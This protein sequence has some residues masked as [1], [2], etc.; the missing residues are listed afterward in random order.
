MAGV[1]ETATELVVAG[2]YA[3][4]E[5]LLRPHVNRKRDDSAAAFLLGHALVR[6]GKPEQALFY[7]ERAAASASAPPGA[8]V[9]FGCTLF[10]LG[11][12]QAGIDVLSRA[13]REHSGHLPAHT[14]LSRMLLR[15]G[16]FVDAMESAM[17]ALAL[18][19]RGAEA[20]SIYASC[21]AGLGRAEDAAQWFERAV[22]L[23]PDDARLRANLCFSLCGVAGV[24]PARVF[25]AHREYGAR[26][27]ADAG[28]LPAPQ[29]DRS[30]T[31]RLRVGFVSPD[32]RDH[33]V[34]RFLLP[35]LRNVEKDAF[36][37]AVYAANVE[38]DDMT[39]ALRACAGLWREVPT[40]TDSDLATQIRADGVDV[41]VDLAG[42][43]GGTRL[44]AFAWKPAPVQ[45]TYMGYPNT[46]GVAGV[47]ARLVDAI[48]DPPGAES[49]ASEALVRL[50]GCFL[51]FDASVLPDVG[52]GAPART[53]GVVFGSFNNPTKLSTHAL[54]LWARVLGANPG[55]RLALKG[56]GFADARCRGAFERRF[57]EAGVDISRV[58]LLPY[59][60][61]S[62]EHLAAYARIDVALDT[63]PYG[64]TT[65][66]CEALAMGVPVVSRVGTTH[67]SR[68]GASLLHAA[69]CDAWAAGD[70]DAFVHAASA[71]A[72]E[73]PAREALAAHVRSSPL[74][75]CAAFTRRFEHAIRELWRAR[76]ARP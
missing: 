48:T 69:G 9:E 14:A 37:V 49:F 46:T 34:A 50:P 63:Y 54:R 70:D 43:T 42:L 36:D 58:D 16:L 5:G 59:A 19:E 32:M 51:C 13:V 57:A 18:D 73:R 10:D 7:L 62:A 67:A 65:T 29:F 56:K 17:R 60:K 4:A 40:I 35:V 72:R 61:S 1:V 55:L 23:K 12:Y 76:V 74:C 52:S 26:V 24:D 3:Q 6:L 2:R 28:V 71:L 39:S 25:A 45:C 53:G 11:K 15:G 30:P 33:P 75:D 41:L 8:L 66:T 38:R 44:G 21:L 68:V 47:D 22:L 27:S 64:G 31:R 20:V